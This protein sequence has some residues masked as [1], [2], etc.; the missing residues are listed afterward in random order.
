MVDTIKFDIPLKLTMKDLREIKWTS[1]TERE[2]NGKVKCFYNIKENEFIGEPF[3]SYTFDKDE[4]TKCWLRV[5]VSLPKFR[6]GTNFYE[7]NDDEMKWTLNMLKVYL[8]KKLKISLNRLP[9]V[10]SWTIKKMH[11]CKN[12][13]VGSNMQVYLSNASKKVLQKRKNTSYKASGKDKIQS[14]VWKAKSTAEKVYDKQAEIKE[15]EKNHD[16]F[17][18]LIPKSIGCLRYESE[19]SRS[20]LRILHA[21]NNTSQ[22]LSSAVIKPLLN[23]NLKR[24]NLNFNIQSTEL[25]LVLNLIESDNTISTRSKNSLI[26]FFTKMHTLGESQTKQSYSQAGFYKIKS[27]YDDFHLKNATLITQ[28]LEQLSVNNFDFAKFN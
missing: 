18:A 3:I 1:M 9:G 27:S 17:K 13:N 14:V 6:H 25:K 23:K 21:K 22:I 4:R 19:L 11:V 5:E 8:C 20:D 12:F 10:D 26:A 15:N 16:D 7:L 2:S 24:L 28:N